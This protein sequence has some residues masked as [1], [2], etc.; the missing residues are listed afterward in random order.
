MVSFYA[1]TLCTSVQIKPLLQAQRAV[2]Y[3]AYSYETMNAAMCL[4]FKWKWHICF[5]HR[6]VNQSKMFIKKSVTTCP[7]TLSSIQPWVCSCFVI[8]LA[9]KHGLCILKVCGVS[10]RTDNI[11]CHVILNKYVMRNGLDKNSSPNEVGRKG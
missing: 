2:A 5:W 8:F 6:S 10:S 11:T 4:V 3:N 9:V 1:L 7:H